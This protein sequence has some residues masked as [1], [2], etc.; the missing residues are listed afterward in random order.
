MKR[1]IDGWRWWYDMHINKNALVGAISRI[2]GAKRIVIRCKLIYEWS[3]HTLHTRLLVRLRGMGREDN[4]TVRW[5]KGYSEK[6]KRCKRRLRRLLMIWGMT[7][8]VSNLLWQHHA[9]TMTKLVP[10]RTLGQVEWWRLSQRKTKTH[11]TTQSPISS[12][13]ASYIHNIISKRE[14]SS[15]PLKPKHARIIF[16]HGV[17][18]I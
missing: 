12:K 14:P 1:L 17:L 13:R 7:F 6:K 3:S 9:A 4:V 16:F 8:L 18:R 15:Y 2:H 10:V 11:S 5:S